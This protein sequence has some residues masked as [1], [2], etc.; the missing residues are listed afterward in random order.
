MAF[1]PVSPWPHGNLTWL[2]PA[3]E[4]SEMLLC[5]TDCQKHISTSG[6]SDPSSSG[7]LP[8]CIPII[9]IGERKDIN[10]PLCS[11]E[12]EQSLFPPSAFLS[13]SGRDSCIF[14]IT[15]YTSHI[16]GHLTWT[17]TVFQMHRYRQNTPSTGNRWYLCFIPVGRLRGAGNSLE[18]TEQS[19]VNQQVSWVWGSLLFRDF[20][21]GQR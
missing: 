3:W 2:N 12:S 7:S 17:G 11:E 15:S 8:L 5:A 14:L 1:I 6:L 21:F 9:L 10:L 13:L 19:E 16:S 4:K 18:H 20:L